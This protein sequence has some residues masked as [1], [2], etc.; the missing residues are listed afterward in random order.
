MPSQSLGDAPKEIQGSDVQHD[1][2]TAEPS[3][4]SLED[5][6]TEDEDDIT[7]D[8]DELDDCDS[9]PWD[10]DDPDGE[11]EADD[12]DNVAPEAAASADS[13]SADE[14]ADV[15]A[16]NKLLDSVELT[17]T[18]EVG[19]TTVS[20]RA[21]RTLRPGYTFELTTPIESSVA[22]KAYG[23]LVG[24]GELVQ[25]EDRLGVRLLEVCGHER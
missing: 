13:E 8:L 24:H 3:L 17:L 18:F 15:D 4:D 23:Q 14:H 10:D 1:D 2:T 16:A 19:E 12:D 22:I 20:I 9:S 5:G 6:V 21:L 11:E 7:E 25:I